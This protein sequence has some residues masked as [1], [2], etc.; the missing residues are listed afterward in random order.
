MRAVCVPNEFRSAG[1]VVSDFVDGFN[2]WRNLAGGAKQ[3]AALLW[4]GDMMFR[5]SA[6]CGYSC[7][8]FRGCE[9]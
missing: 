1:T 4:G 7:T 6:V 9:E 2:S 8:V 5:R 3:P